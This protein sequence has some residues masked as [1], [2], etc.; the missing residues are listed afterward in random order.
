LHH[1]PQFVTRHGSDAVVIV[2]FED[3]KKIT[4]PKTDLVSFFKN[5]PLAGADID[6]SR[7]K[8]LPR[9]IEL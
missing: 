9:E 4:K 1:E 8:D 6:I 3:Y 5:S 7:N 2:S